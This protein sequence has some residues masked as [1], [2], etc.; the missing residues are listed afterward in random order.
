LKRRVLFQFRV[1]LTQRLDSISAEI[2]VLFEILFKK[3]LREHYDGTFG[4]IKLALGQCSIVCS[5]HTSLF[6]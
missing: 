6:E 1:N 2:K 3:Y 4:H 5:V